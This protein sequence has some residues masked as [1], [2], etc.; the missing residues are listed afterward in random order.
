MRIIDLTQPMA[1]GMPVMPGIS[2]PRFRDTADVRTDG[3][4]MSEYAFVNHTGT[5]VDAPA[6]Q[7]AGGATLDDIPLR[8]LVTDA[9][10][11]D[12]SAHPPGPV[13]L[14]GLERHLPEVRANDI[15]LFSS[16][17]A[18]NWGTDAYWHGW[19]Y[20]DAPAAQALIGRGISG[21]GFDG[22]SADPV[23]SIDYE[24]HHVWLGS[25][26]IIIENLASLAQLPARCRIVVAP[27]KV[28]GANGGPA[29]I[30]AL[31]D[32]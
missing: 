7:I 18:A 25:G 29:R 23:D 6:H 5:H 32:D 2:P 15:V 9:V 26:K 22:P 10:T 30:Y 24:L 20:P 13:G 21:V 12:L 19:C 4:A 16:G 11:I 3:Y 27:L 17:N 1:N 31:L 14:A 28:R 8:R